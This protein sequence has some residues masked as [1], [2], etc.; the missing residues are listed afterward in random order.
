[1]KKTIYGALVAGAGFAAFLLSASPS[2]VAPADAGHAAWP[3]QS[4]PA[5]V[6]SVAASSHAPCEQATA[7]PDEIRQFS[8]SR[9]AGQ[10]QL[11]LSTAL[12]DPASALTKAEQGHSAAAIAVLY[13]AANCSRLRG[14]FDFFGLVPDD[15]DLPSMRTCRQLPRQLRRSPLTVLDKVI[16]AA[17]EAQLLYAANGLLVRQAR[18][19]EVVPGSPGRDDAELASELASIEKKALRAAHAGVSEAYLFLAMHY[20][21]GSLGAVDA[22][23]AS[24]FARQF[25]AERPDAGAARRLAYFKQRSPSEAAPAAPCGKGGGSRVINPF[26]GRG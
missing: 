13:L 2:S 3:T 25:H 19:A 6:T 24:Y 11:E 21:D 12:T 4:V 5:P 17:P 10:V 23:K 26:S 7:E 15:L 9:L 20:D 16:E 22:H 18:L 1:M 8:I 14:R